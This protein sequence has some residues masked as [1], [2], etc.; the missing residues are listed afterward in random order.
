MEALKEVTVWDGIEHRQPNHIYLMDGDTAL[1]YVK[2][3]E[4]EP[5]YFKKGIKMDKRGRKFVKADMG[6]FKKVE[7]VETR[8]RV[9]GSKGAVYWVDP[10]EKTC[11]CPGYTF[12]GQC[13]HVAEL[14]DN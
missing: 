10:E 8:L 9:E 7:P 13:K 1:A 3:G 6:L 12:R 4:G 14:V 11:T 5:F 2:W